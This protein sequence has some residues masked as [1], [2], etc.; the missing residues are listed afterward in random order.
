MQNMS[1]VQDKFVISHSD[2]CSINVSPINYT[3]TNTHTHVHSLIVY[4]LQKQERCY[5]PQVCET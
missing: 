2:S 3:H 5:L 4:E 1:P